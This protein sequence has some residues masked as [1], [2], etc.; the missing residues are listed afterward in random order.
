MNN[1]L[2][3]ITTIDRGGAENHL[4]SLVKHQVILGKRI[5]ICYL[6]GKGYW[7][8]EYFSRGVR[9]EDLGLKHYGDIL[10]IKKLRLMISEI[11]PDVVHAHMPPAELYARIALLTSGSTRPT[12]IITKHNDKDFYRGIGHRL[13][14]K[15]VGRRA[16]RIITISDAVKRYVTEVEGICPPEKSVTIRYGIDTKLIESVNGNEVRRVRASWGVEDDVLLIGTISRLVPQKALHVLLNGYE[17]FLR[18]AI[19]PS[20][21]VIVGQ[22]PLEDKLKAQAARLGIEANVIWAGFRE[23]I[24]T[25]INALDVFALTSVHEGFGLVLLE[26]MAAGKPVVASNVSAIPEVVENDI[27]GILV[28]PETPHRLSA[29]FRFFEDR[30]NR[31]KFGEAGYRRVKTEFDFVRMVEKTDKVYRDCLNEE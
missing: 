19:S 6:K 20:K 9:V 31:M 18:E 11:D 3:V 4:I 27:T 26:A 23:D 24:P 10:P 25:V 16:S 29:A 1:I 5:Y 12:F 21:L 14:G 7:K 13:L 8:N 17:L 15:W 28:P 22:G 30:E 2:H